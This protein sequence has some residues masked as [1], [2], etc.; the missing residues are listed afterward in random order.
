M[1]TY[2]TTAASKLL[3]KF[4]NELMKLLTSD[5]KLFTA[6]NPF[7]MNKTLATEQQTMAVA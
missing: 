5:L 4:D 1:K 6:R 2:K 7:L 3:T